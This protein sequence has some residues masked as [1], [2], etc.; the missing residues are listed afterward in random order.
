MQ[1]QNET[2]RGSLASVT[3]GFLGATQRG[4][5]SEFGCA[6]C[7]FAMPRYP[8]RY[9]AA[10]PKCGGTVERRQ[11]A[12]AEKIPGGKAAG[13]KPS[14]FDPGALL[15]GIRVEM[16]HT[17]DAALAMEIAMDHLAEDPAYY[18][19]LATIHPPEEEPAEGGAGSGF[20]GAPDYPS[21]QGEGAPIPLAS[22]AC[23]IQALIEAGAQGRYPYNADPDRCSRPRRLTAA[24]VEEL[25]PGG[26]AGLRMFLEQ[27]NPE[28][29]YFRIESPAAPVLICEFHVGGDL[30]IYATVDPVTYLGFDP[31]QELVSES[32]RWPGTVD[33]HD[34]G[35]DII[36]RIAGD[37][38]QLED[39]NTWKVHGSWP[40]SDLM[41]D[42]PI[43][44]GIRLAGIFLDAFVVEQILQAAG[45]RYREWAN[46]IVGAI[47]AADDAALRRGLRGMREG[48]DEEVIRASKGLGLSRDDLPQIDSDKI[49]DFLEWLRVQGI[50]V[51][52]TEATARLLLPSQGEL[53][54]DKIAAMAKEPEKLTK[55]KIITSAD[56]Y[57]LDG[58]HRWAA[59]V[60]VYPEGN[61][62]VWQVQLDIVT[63]INLAKLFPGAKVRD[64]SGKRV[65][66]AADSKIATRLSSLAARPM[67][68]FKGPTCVGRAW[69][70]MN[71]PRPWGEFACSSCLTVL[72]KE[73]GLAEAVNHD[74][75]TRVVSAMRQANLQPRFEGGIA[76]TPDVGYVRAMALG[77]VA[78][79]LVFAGARLVSASIVPPDAPEDDKAQIRAAVMGVLPSMADIDLTESAEMPSERELSDLATGAT[80]VTKSGSAIEFRFPH[81]RYVEMAHDAIHAKWPR[82]GLQFS[83][84]KN[85]NPVLIVSPPYVPPVRRPDA[86]FSLEFYDVSHEG[87]EA[88]ILRDIAAAGG[89]VVGRHRSGEELSV[90]ISA[91]DGEDAFMAKFKRTRSASRLNEARLEETRWSRADLNRRFKGQYHNKGFELLY[92]DD[93]ADAGG[94][95]K[96]PRYAVISTFKWVEAPVKGDSIMDYMD[97]IEAEARDAMMGMRVVDV[98]D[99]W[100][101]VDIDWRGLEEG[102]MPDDY[103]PSQA[104]AAIRGIMAAQEKGVIPVTTQAVAAFGFGNPRYTDLARQV[105]SRLQDQGYVSS[106]RDQGWHLYQSAKYWLAEAGGKIVPGEGPQAGGGACRAVG[107]FRF[108]LGK[109]KKRKPRKDVQRAIQNRLNAKRGLASR[110]SAAKKWHQSSQGRR[111][112]RDLGRY[113]RQESYWPLFERETEFTNRYQA[114]GLAEPDP[115][116]MCLGACEGTGMVPVNY[117]PAKAGGIGPDPDLTYKAAWEAAEAASP[118]E[119]GWHF[120]KC[121]GCG[122]SGKATRLNESHLPPLVGL[123]RARLAVEVE[124]RSGLDRGPADERRVLAAI[125][126]VEAGD[127]NN[128]DAALKRLVYEL[129]FS[130]KDNPL[131]GLREDVGERTVD[132]RF[133]EFLR[134][135]ITIESTDVLQDVNFTDDGGIYLFFDPSLCGPDL[136]EILMALRQAQGSEGVEI[137]GT[138]DEED[139]DWW[140]IFSPPPTDSAACVPGQETLDQ[141][142]A[143]DEVQPVDGAPA[144]LASMAVMKQNSVDRLAMSVD[145]PALMQGIDGAEAQNEATERVYYRIKVDGKYVGSPT[146]TRTANPN[147]AATWGTDERDQAEK[148]AKL[149]PGAVVE[150]YLYKS[151]LSECGAHGPVIPEALQPREDGVVVLLWSAV[152][153]RVP[154]FKGIA[155]GGADLH[156]LREAA[157]QGKGT[158]FLV[159]ALG[160]RAARDTIRTGKGLHEIAPNVLTNE[161]GL[162]HVL[163]AE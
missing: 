130:L 113:L 102:N 34:P 125:A 146:N 6:G 128:P 123:D 65:A 55:G 66:E 77:N 40:L 16:E 111:Y 73:A 140:V 68:Q 1:P 47:H 122:G 76:P 132:D 17:S 64:I 129:W 105:L 150:P 49:D 61:M 135:L 106:D 82:L 86:P 95:R 19:K 69:W 74:I 57:V 29:R 124:R 141:Q 153:S 151:M 94:G 134:K 54:S 78:L 127:L 14:D 117:A 126:A 56:G 23:R 21:W 131:P 11:V 38:F 71:T 53:E 156:G 120:V 32:S 60:E 89:K 31:R 133:D 83:Q 152:E 79:E 104:R 142:A 63:L 107:G 91:P 42:D 160:A 33:V 116:T 10:C 51:Y 161:V 30:V 158:L 37:K 114:L 103:T 145:I 50:G 80:A 59:Y 85:G 2:S 143:G 52:P 7:G 98:G 119:D 22:R 101:V 157:A 96:Q 162:A 35:H 72:E 5:L 92:G 149:I 121:L 154:R 36:A 115:A 44:K 163:A 99:D 3:P 144:P 84:S 70:K 39:V 20:V 15:A 27:G 109:S 26:A 58:H 136:D 28:S 8:G 9:P 46:R 88:P 67:C 97:E 108:E 24:Q 87:D 18:D 110:I 138:P 148:L 12:E 4:R 13:M 112:H 25:C 45:G 48:V 43:R 118:A 100:A 147:L 137:V 75:V 93:Q 81:G 155:S 41:K 62:P 159:R 139:S 90:D